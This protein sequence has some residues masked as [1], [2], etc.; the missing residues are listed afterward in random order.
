MLFLESI[1]S[2][3][4]ELETEMEKMKLMK[5]I[6]ATRPRRRN[7]EISLFLVGSNLPN[8]DTVPTILVQNE[9]FQEPSLEQAGSFHK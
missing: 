5:D 1:T 9:A 4:K 3:H 7:S 2:D 6:S 8:A